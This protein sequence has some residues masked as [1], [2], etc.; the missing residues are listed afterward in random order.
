MKRYKNLEKYQYVT[1]ICT[2]IR[3]LIR[4]IKVIA[5]AFIAFASVRASWPADTIQ[6]DL[7]NRKKLNYTLAASAINLTGMTILLN[8][9]W[10]KN[11][12]RS[13][14]HFYD[15]SG[16]W[17]QMDKAGH[18]FTSYALS[19]AGIELMR[20]TGMDNTRAYGM[21][22]CTDRFFFQ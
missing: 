19:L 21:A 15:D 20:N 6:F 22:V 1:S 8:E 11:H 10:Y 13:S 3:C 2:K 7:L 9:A 14:F 12:D 18:F 5:L 16:E 17:L 4:K